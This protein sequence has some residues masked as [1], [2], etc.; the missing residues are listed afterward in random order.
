MKQIFFVFLICLLLFVPNV[1]GAPLCAVY[2]DHEAYHTPPDMVIRDSYPRGMAESDVLS[3]DA[4]VFCEVLN[5]S[6]EPERASE[7]DD[8][9]TALYL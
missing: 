5:V 1:Y 3:L 6:L 4:D 7:F 9:R 2:T 8:N